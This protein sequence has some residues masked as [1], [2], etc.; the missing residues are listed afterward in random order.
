MA[1]K[2]REEESGGSWMDTYGDL[3]TLLLTFFVMLYGM[4]SMAEDKWAELVK[5][6]NPD[7]ST[8]VEQIV[9]TYDKTE[10]ENA[11]NNT[12]EGMGDTPNPDINEEV[13][14][15]DFSK[16][17]DYLN[18]YIEES[19]M[20]DSIAIEQGEEIPMEGQ[21]QAGSQNIYIQFK[22]DVL[23]MP[24]DS[25]LRPESMDM[26]NFIGECLS[27]IE[28]EI[29]LVIVKGH[30]AKASGES[31]VDSRLLSSARA[32]TVT[33][34]FEDNFGMP[35]TMLIPMG[36]AGD[37]PIASNDTDE[38]RAQNRRVEMVIIGKNSQFGQSSELLRILGA[39]FN[40]DVGDV[41]DIVDNP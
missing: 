5:A 29:A 3:V 33:N 28:D 7:G 21:T 18:E 17:F 6:F 26:M 37:Y 1:K 35:S 24:D 15:I 16:L 9:F 4:S 12:G 27:S 10:G 32:S 41:G 23:F 19:H 13:V 36:L 14:A 40:L 8:E 11:L 38:G 34:L 22:N 25:E 39:S 2:H 30:T 31:D 20:E